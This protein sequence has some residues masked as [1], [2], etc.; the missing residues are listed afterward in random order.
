[1]HPDLE[2]RRRVLTKTYRS[3]LAADRA[4]IDAS[5]EVQTWVPRQSRLTMS[6]IGNPGS[7]IRAIYDG[8]DRA[9]RQ[10]MVARLKLESAKQRVL[11]RNSARNPQQVLLALHLVR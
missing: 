10:L 1:M 5:R 7:R 8:R 6:A 9:L 2:L 3:Y 11:L 4:W